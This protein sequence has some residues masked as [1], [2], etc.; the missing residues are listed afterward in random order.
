MF[1]QGVKRP[2]RKLPL[3]RE[4]AKQ[5]VTKPAHHI[6]ILPETNGGHFQIIL[7]RVFV[8]SQDTLPGTP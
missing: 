7:V 8:T 4:Q 1:L 6:Y 5:N 3:S 2:L